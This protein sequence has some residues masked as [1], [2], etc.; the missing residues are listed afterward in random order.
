MSV[1]PHCGSLYD[2]WQTLEHFHSKYAAE[3]RRGVKNLR[4]PTRYA[5]PELDALLD[6]HAGP[7]AVA[8]R[9][10]TMSNS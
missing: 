5:N 8:R 10:P 6:S 4:A 3:G 9:T 1:F 7:A 2:P